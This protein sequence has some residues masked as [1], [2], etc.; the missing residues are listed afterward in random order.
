MRFSTPQRA[1]LGRFQRNVRTLLLR[2]RRRPLD[3]IRWLPGQ[4]RFLHD[5]GGKHRM[6]LFRAGNQAHGKTWA[7]LAEAHY[8]AIGKH[9]FIDVPKGPV[10]IWVICAAWAQSIS[11]Q[12]KFWQLAGRSGHLHEDTEFDPVKGFRGKNPAVRYK[13]GS[14]LRFKTTN[15]GGLNL[16]GATIDFALFDEP[17][18]DQR[19]FGEV[20]KRVMRR[21]GT[22]ALTLTPINAPTDW[23]KKLVDEGVVNETHVRLEPK[24]LIPVGASKPLRLAD[25]TPMDDAW[26]ERIRLETVPHEAP[27]VLDGEWEIRLEDRVFQAFNKLDHVHDQ[28]PVGREVNVALGVDYGTK[29]G[30][31]VAILVLFWEEKR[32]DQTFF[33]I[34]VLDEYVDEDGK[35]A[36]EDDARGIL[37]MLRRHGWG[38]HNLD[39]AWGD[40][41]YLRGPATRKSNKDLQ[42][43]I[44]RQLRM[45]SG[46]LTPDIRTA[47]RGAGKGGG[48]VDVGVRF[49]HHAMVR[50]LFGVHPRCEHLIE[51]FFKWKYTEDHKDPID[52]LRYALEPQIFGVGRRRGRRRR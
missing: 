38:W 28:L 3:Y 30:K 42:A 33:G 19:I 9:P 46:D 17:P 8:R 32:D 31:Q 35:S 1:A 43:A 13:N 40:R 48:S 51:S 49:L 12:A 39:Q 10:E 7:G 52:A 15:Q 22:V 37:R 41:L 25:G 23:L 4:W 24:N 29:A 34:Y 50:G 44:A 16:A 2:R 18:K 45:S 11:I 36:P 20:Q 47:K 26:I 14:I 21:A 6:K 27:V 5:D